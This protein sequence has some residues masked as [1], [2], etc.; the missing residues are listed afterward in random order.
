MGDA[1]HAVEAGE[2]PVELLRALIAQVSDLV[3]LSDRVGT[4]AWANVGFVE[5]TGFVAGSLA[6]SLLAFTPSG[7]SGTRARLALGEMLASPPREAAGVE[8]RGKDGN[9]VR[10]D[11]RVQSVG[12]QLLWTMRDVTRE[13]ALSQQASRQ[14]ELLQTTQEFGRL[15]IW[16]RAI[17]SGE[18]RWDAHVF[19]FWGLDPEGGTPTHEAA[20]ERIHP[21]D[22]ARMNYGDSTRRAGRYAQRYRVVHPD[23]SVRWIHSQWEVRNGVHGVPDR[24]VGVMM[25]DTESYQ[26][27]R[28][29]VGA[30][31]QLQ[32]AVELGKIS[33]WRHDLRTDRMFCSEQGFE[34][35]GM[36]PRSEGH[37]ADEV[38]SYIHPDDLPAVLSSAQA[39]L[40][41]GEP[42]DVETRYRRADGSWRYVLTR[43]VVERD[44]GGR[45]IAFLGV[46]LD[47]TERL[48]NLRH[49]EEMARRLDAASRA[50]GV[51]IWTMTLEPSHTDWNEQMFVLF[52][53]FTPPEVPTFGRWLA[54]SLHPDDRER[55]GKTARNYLARGEG[56]FEIE[57][58][59]VRRD[60]STRWVVMRAHV[61]GGAHAPRRVLGVA[62]DVTDHHEAIDA[63]REAS[64][65][66]AFITHHAGIGVWEASMTGEGGRWDDRMFELRGLP[67]GPQ[68]PNRAERM[69]M[70]HPDDAAR[71]LDSLR[72]TPGSTLTSSY[73]F[74][75]RLP[76]GSYRWLASRSAVVVDDAGRPIR[77]VGANWD[78]TE[79]KNAELA[80]QQAALAVREVEAKSQFLSRMSHELRTPLNAVLGFTQILQIEARR[81]NSSDQ[82]AKLEHIRSAGDHL[83]SLINDVLDLSGLESGELRLSM[84]PV[85]V[86]ALVAEALPLVHA[87]AEQ[88]GVELEVRGGGG[89][90]RADPTRLR[91]VL[92]NLLS[93]A[94]KYN[95]RGGRVV[96]ATGSD[97]DQTRLVVQDTGR[98]LGREQLASLFE[99]FNR[100]GVEHEGIEGTGIGLTIVKALVDGMGGSIEVRSEPGTGTTFEVRLP[101]AAALAEEDREAPA[102]EV[103]AAGQASEPRPAGTILYIEDNP[104]NVLL[105]EELVKTIGGLTVASE[106]TGGAGVARA[107]EL[108]PDLVLVDLQLPDFDGYEVLRRLRADPATTAIRC[109]ALSAN[110]MPEDIERGL[111]AGFADY[112]TK[113]I[114]F[115]LFIAALK[116]LFPGD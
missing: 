39:A 61:D 85:D 79:S 33:I 112:W 68:V 22:R 84:R 1:D 49:G 104:V 115:A 40:K 75:V 87:L 77:R 3:V 59:T 7:P 4:I 34:L 10:V 83:L 80:R 114:D 38:R 108:Q 106:A 70:V 19:D 8:L 17:P 44:D 42:I 90:A 71:V 9:A 86:A 58:R 11:A 5:A 50:A 66:A 2:P 21:E 103:V 15:G 51:G 81:S 27:A 72:A 43:R 65:R 6:S 113:P 110:A 64:R 111:A 32:M 96:V 16:E 55:I 26:A 24:A 93:N 23:G 52:D 57:F 37:L 25:D 41:T 13:H 63:L 73:E 98:G 91:Q 99:P 67:P 12:G 82:L 48:E 94:I 74:R 69:A 20:I 62:M 101:A 95:R 56:A 102:P 60:G 76:D 116:A 45:P 88:H 18:G 105:V 35:L 28:A 46:A 92:I 29:L 78:V 14:G 97:G 47:M 30:N 54:E 100:F 31:T 36:S 53:H 89:I 107:R 109:V